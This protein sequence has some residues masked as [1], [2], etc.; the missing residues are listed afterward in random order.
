MQTAILFPGQGSQVPGMGRD[1][2]EASRD[3]MDM[4]KKAEKL[5][6]LELRSI[7]WESDDAAAMAD[8]R[9]LQPALTVVTLTLWQAALP[10]LARG[11]F[12]PCGAAGH[13]LGEYSAL[14]AA[15]AL[16]ADEALELVTLRGALM[17]DADPDGRGG[18]AAVLKLPQKAIEATVAEAKKLLDDPREVLLIAN[19]NTPGQFVVSGTKT[20]LEALAPLVKA[21]RGR[22]M[23]L[24]VSG[25]FHSPLMHEAG[26]KLAAKIAKTTWS[27]PRFPVYC[28]A[29]GRAIA[30]RKELETLLSCQM[31][32]S[33]H[34]IDTILQ[35]WLDGARAWIE[36]GPKGVLSRMVRPNLEHGGMTQEQL[37]LVR[38]QAV[39][40]LE[41]ID[42]LVKADQ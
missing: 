10:V 2:A 9:A 42:G 1:V 20:A 41:G 4:W 24:A 27:T 37:A 28:N 14:V 6:G 7:Y 17:A 19:Y 25:A 18:M 34:W 38:I 39:D 3:A 22:M 26:K 13:S 36:F 35:Q 5:S 29:V 33:V 11:G 12:E 30:D 32:A 21:Q 15:G 40:S 8:T 16:R 23:P 31:T